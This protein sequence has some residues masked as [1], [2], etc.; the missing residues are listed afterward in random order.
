MVRGTV[1]LPHGTA[2]P[3][4]DRVRDCD[5]AAEAEAAGARRV[6]S[7]DL[8]ERIQGGFLDFDAAI[9][10]PDQMAKVGPGARCSGRVA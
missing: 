10:T 4:G 3:P 7:D 5:K 2:R 6:G 9:A 8:V 1:N